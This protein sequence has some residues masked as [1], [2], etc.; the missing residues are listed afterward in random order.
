VRTNT[1]E[2]DATKDSFS[3]VA[4]QRAERQVPNSGPDGTIATEADLGQRLVNLNDKNPMT[5]SE[6]LANNTVYS[7]ENLL[8]FELKALEITEMKSVPKHLKRWLNDYTR[9]STKLR[10]LMVVQQPNATPTKSSEGLYRAG[11]PER[12]DNADRRLDYASSKNR[13]KD[14]RV[15]EVSPGNLSSDSDGLAGSKGT[16]ETPVLMDARPIRDCAPDPK[17]EPIPKIRLN[18]LIIRPETFDGT[19]PPPRQWLDDYER[20][21]HANGWRERTMVKHLQTFI[22]KA[23][24]DWYVTIAK[25]K[26]GTDPSWQEVRAAFLRHYLGGSDKA[27]VRRQIERTRQGD[28]EKASLF[29]PRLLRLFDM[30]EPNKPEEELVEI[31]RSKLRKGYQDKLA[32]HDIYG[33]RGSM[34][35]V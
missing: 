11:S 19:K 1:I 33:L 31:L 5:L 6:Y 22:I 10:K 12:G 32:M 30:V 28:N 21:A 26:L 13:W 24:Q 4:E 14:A 2:D 34:T 27:V 16:Q 35:S 15:D 18:E 20:A 25:R 17:E 23:A 8:T 3:T 29:I 7:E 9:A